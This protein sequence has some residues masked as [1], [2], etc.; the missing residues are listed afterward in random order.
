MAREVLPIVG[1]AVGAAVGGP[2][3]AQWGFAIGSIVGNAVDPTVY[4]GPSI[5]DGQVQTSRDGVPIPMIWGIVGGIAGNIIQMNPLVR[6]TVKSGSKKEGYTEN[7]KLT[8]TFAIGIGRGPDGPIAGIIRCWENNKLIYDA[9]LGT[10]FPAADNAAFLDSCTIY[11]GDETQ[12]PDSELESYT[13]VGS[14]PAYRGLAYIVFNNKDLTSFAGAIP[15]YKFEVWRAGPGLSADRVIEWYNFDE[16]S[17]PNPNAAHLS[18]ADGNMRFDSQNAYNSAVGI[19][20][21]AAVLSATG[22][23]YMVSAETHATSPDVGEYNVTLRDQV[24]S[25]SLWFKTHST[26]AGQGQRHIVSQWWEGAFAT[27]GYRKWRLVYNS[28]EN[29][30]KFSIG[31]G[32]LVSNFTDLDSGDIGLQP[33]T[34]YHIVMTHDPD[35]DEMTLTVSERGGTFGTRKSAAIS[36]G[37]YWQTTPTPLPTMS[38][39]IAREK[40]GSSSYTSDGVLDMLAFWDT[41]SILTENEARALFEYEMTYTDLT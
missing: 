39:T 34:W 25:C 40:S 36:G 10:S 37:A 18:V 13:G 41:Q 22:S 16:A 26:L 38:M 12:T 14:T 31:Q 35:A 21:G 9:R 30:F 6:T 20:N 4:K 15:Q 24:W 1:A 2:A 19:A 28:A 8:R 23:Q 5:G 29:G 17:D 11:L 3:G 32:P 7:E 27:L 33:S